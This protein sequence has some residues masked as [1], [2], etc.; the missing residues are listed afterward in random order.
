MRNI[1]FIAFLS[2]LFAVTS[3]Y[4]AKIT[5]GEAP[6]AKKIDEPWAHGFI[7]GLV[8]PKEINSANE[9]P[10]GVAMVETKIS[11]LNGLVSLVTFNLYTPMHITVTCATGSGMSANIDAD[12]SVP[13]NSTE[14]RIID[15][16]ERASHKAVETQ[17]PVFVR[18]E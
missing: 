17:L 11:F 6:S 4:H 12:I 7:F 8:P 14:E 5:T 18:F 9:C 2:I 3:C 10:N 1:K 13:E 15:A 16:F